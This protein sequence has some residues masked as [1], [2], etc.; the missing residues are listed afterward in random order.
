MKSIKKSGIRESTIAKI[1]HM[2]NHIRLLA[3]D[4]FVPEKEVFLCTGAKD[5]VFKLPISEQLGL[6]NNYNSTNAVKA[7]LIERKKVNGVWHVMWL[8]GKFVTEG[9]VFSYYNII[10]GYKEK[11]IA[12]K[13][14]DQI[15]A[16]EAE[17][18]TAQTPAQMVDEI[19]VTEEVNA[20]EE[21]SAS[22]AIDAIESESI[23]DKA[24]IALLEAKVDVLETVLSQFKASFTTYCKILGM[25]YAELAETVESPQKMVDEPQD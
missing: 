2:L 19:I 11:S 14:E 8:G 18:A 4:G 3:Y 24:R 16:K 5:R 20:T 21:I 12:K 9:H 17:L 23:P 13:L 1:S 25:T 22:K 6:D 15:K 7:G 10:K